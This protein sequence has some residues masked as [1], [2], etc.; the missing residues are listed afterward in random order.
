MGILRVLGALV[1][2]RRLAWGGLGGVALRLRFRFPTLW[3]GCPGGR[4][5]VAPEPEEMGGVSP[6]HLNV[7]DLSGERRG[8]E[9]SAGGR[10]LSVPLCLT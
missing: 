7:D 1:R 4:A 2:A 8:L 6:K 10:C 3:C 9:W 5:P